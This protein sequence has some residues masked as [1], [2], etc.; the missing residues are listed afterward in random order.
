MQS[1]KKAWLTSLAKVGIFYFIGFTLFFIISFIIINIRV[2]SKA[3]V[4][5][6][7]MVGHLY[8]DEH[9]FLVSSGLAVKLDK[10]ELIEYPYGYILSQNYAPGKDIKQGTTI[11]LLVNFSK[12]I[13][14]VP[15]IVGVSIELVDHILEQIPVGSKTFSLKKGVVSNIPSD[16][17]VGEVLAQFP[18]AGVTV[19]P[20]YPVSILVSDGPEKRASVFPLPEMKNMH[21][22]IVK[23][24]AYE[25]KI[26]LKIVSKLTENYK[27]NGRVI[28]ISYKG[29]RFNPFLDHSTEVWDV[30]VYK[31]KRV[32]DTNRYPNALVWLKSPPKIAGSVWTVATRNS[33]NNFSEISYLY[34]EK[35]IPV[36]V[37]QEKEIV[38]WQGYIEENIFQTEESLQ[39]AKNENPTNRRYL[40]ST[41][42]KKAEKKPVPKEQY[43]LRL[44]SIQI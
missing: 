27:E 2:S 3:R 20:E 25:L 11:T 24:I 28:S 34:I 30:F 32:D 14:P 44:N 6:P 16:H 23:K 8:L 9:N 43:K 4:R 40:F 13:V 31:Y 22:D 41:D 5:V 18:P 10:A 19:F 37:N 29:N 33:Q 1:E 21:I 15:Q 12:N 7:D 35:E 38:F 36:F 26:P 42:E 39:N 17:P